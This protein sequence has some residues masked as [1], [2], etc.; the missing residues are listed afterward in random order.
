M[1][2]DK[3]VLTDGF[4][5]CEIRAVYDK[6]FTDK[7]PLLSKKGE[8]MITVSWLA[9]DSQ[10]NEAP[11]KDFIAANAVQKILNLENALNIRGL[12]NSDTRTFNVSLLSH[13]CCGAVIYQDENPMY[14]S[15]IKSYVPLAFY[16]LVNEKTT[17]DKVLQT[18]A[19]PLPARAAYIAGEDDDIPF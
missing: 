6:T 10:G 2:N 4:A 9:V 8:P 19:M 5:Y 17:I 3:I 14:G 16:K 7:T 18:N 13:A 11:L 15:K 12:Y 1:N